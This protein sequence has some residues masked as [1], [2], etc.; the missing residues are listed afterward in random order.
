MGIHFTSRT[1]PNI[2]QKEY[3][4]NLLTYFH[5]EAEEKDKT[6]IAGGDINSFMKGFAKPY[7][8][9]PTREDDITTFKKRTALQAQQ[10]KK[11]IRIKKSIDKI[12]TNGNILSGSISLIDGIE[13]DLLNKKER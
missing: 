8:F 3:L 6:F 7:D 4:T 13:P 9:Y 12:I 5:T 11:D 10:R 1:P 2:R